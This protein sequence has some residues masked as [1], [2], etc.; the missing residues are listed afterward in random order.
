M[1]QFELRFDASGL[2]MVLL[3]LGD[4]SHLETVPRPPRVDALIYH[5]EMGLPVAEAIARVEPALVLPTHCLEL[6]HATTGEHA[7]R[8][9]Y[10]HA[11]AKVT[12]LPPERVRLLTW[13]ER[14][15]L[16]GTVA[17]VPV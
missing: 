10:A 4:Q 2:G 9:S 11:L 13:G 6:G 8:W 16:P 12:H 17:E 1:Q 14:L 3:H 15:E 7:W 5:T